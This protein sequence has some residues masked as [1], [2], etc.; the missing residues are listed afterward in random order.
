[1]QASYN[2]IGISFNLV[3]TDWVVNADWANNGRDTE[4]IWKP[5]L[6]QGDYRVLN[7]YFIK[8]WAV[9]WGTCN[10][11]E[12]HANDPQPGK[13]DLDGCV[14]RHST[15]PGG[16]LST[17]GEGKTT[18]HEV[19]HWFG[20]WHTYERHDYEDGCNPVGDMVDDTSRQKEA[21]PGHC[22][23]HRNTCPDP[24]WPEG[25]DPEDPDNNY[26]GSSYDQCLTEFT[27]GQM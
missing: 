27:A 25:G 2:S 10:N 9:S 4:E 20:L 14:V 11:P 7:V 12:L 3:G 1:M 13:L 18:V 6:R 26:M 16:P 24:D 5:Q 19:G 15:V 22:G 17:Y 23:K 8:N 21:N